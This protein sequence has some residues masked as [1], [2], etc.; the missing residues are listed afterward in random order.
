[1]RYLTTNQATVC[2]ASFS[3]KADRLE[4]PVPSKMVS[5]WP[6]RLPTAELKLHACAPSLA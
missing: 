4:T 3:S 2:H 6:D 5:T 1:M